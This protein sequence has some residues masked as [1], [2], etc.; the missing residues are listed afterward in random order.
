[1]VDV[2]IGPSRENCYFSVMMFVLRGGGA[3]AVVLETLV[4]VR[5]LGVR[6]THTVLS[7]CLHIHRNRL[8]LVK[9]STLGPSILKYIVI[10][11]I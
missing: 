8:F 10:R 1:M 5:S 4:V 3:L 2:A 9:D 7:S 11:S 6:P